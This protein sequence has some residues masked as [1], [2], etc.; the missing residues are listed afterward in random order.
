MLE[1]TFL[2]DELVYQAPGERLRRLAREPA[3]HELLQVVR[4]GTGAHDLQRQ[5]RKRYADQQLG[6]A[7]ARR[8]LDHHPVI[9]STGENAAAGNGVTVDRRY[10]R[11]RVKEQALQHLSERL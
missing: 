8:V 4:C 11:S 2:V 5:R 9:G 3:I 7:D 1:Y 10:Y 6:R